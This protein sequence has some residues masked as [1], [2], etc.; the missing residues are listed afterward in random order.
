MDNLDIKA[1]RLLA[2]KEWEATRRKSNPDSQFHEPK[3]DKL[4]KELQD[5]WIEDC[6]RF[7]GRFKAIRQR[8]EKK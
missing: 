7:I 6:I 8:L 3:W 1:C 4:S 2:E 5:V